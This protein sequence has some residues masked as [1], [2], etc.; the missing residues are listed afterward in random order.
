MIRAGYDSPAAVAGAAARSDLKH[1]DDRRRDIPL[2][3]APQ[4]PDDDLAPDIR[5]YS[6]E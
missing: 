6:T 3:R 2:R 4:P 5:D 1:A